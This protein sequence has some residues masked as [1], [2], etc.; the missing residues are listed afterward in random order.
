MDPPRARKGRSMWIYPDGSIEGTIG[1]EPME[2]ECINEALDMLKT[3]DTVRVKECN[4]ASGLAAVLRAPSA[5][6]REQSLP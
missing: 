1:G 2:Y 5:E 3:G 6:R 4:L